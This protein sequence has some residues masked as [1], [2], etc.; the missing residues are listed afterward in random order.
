MEH[1]K[2]LWYLVQHKLF[3]MQAGIKIGVPLWRLITHDLSKFL[4]SEWFPYVDY[5]YDPKKVNDK[6]MESFRLFGCTEMAP[7]GFF[8]SDL[9]SIAW[10]QH[11]KRNDHHWQ[12]WYLIEDSGKEFPVGMPWE[13]LAEMVADW[14]GAGR[15]ITGKWD[16]GSWYA[17]NKDKMRLRDTDH[18]RIEKL[19]A[20]LDGG[21]K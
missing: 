4:P 1:L 20:I 21:L 13:A 18:I 14:A 12:Y 16:V 7:Y 11:Q 19:I 5:F 6:T 15:V 3:V 9:F 17:K 8:P 10:C 2:Y